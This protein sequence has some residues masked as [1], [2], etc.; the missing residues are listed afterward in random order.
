MCE[1]VRKLIEDLER[2]HQTFERLHNTLDDID[3]VISRSEASLTD[4]DEST[5]AGSKSQRLQRLHV[6]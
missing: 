2:W 5:V 6:S 4:I 3:T 1:G